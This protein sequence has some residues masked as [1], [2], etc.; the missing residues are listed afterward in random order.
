MFVEHSGPIA[1]YNP[2]PELCVATVKDLGILLCHRMIKAGMR[3]LA[4]QAFELVAPWRADSL[5]LMFSRDLIQLGNR[6]AAQRLL[7][8]FAPL[9]PELFR[10]FKFIEWHN[11]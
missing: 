1:R 4:H 7:N 2:E 10:R 8:G 5:F 9:C 6:N 11:K 3:L